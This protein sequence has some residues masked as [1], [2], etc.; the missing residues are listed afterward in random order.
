MGD[1]VGS[2]ADVALAG[3][4]VAAVL[5][6]SLTGADAADSVPAVSGGRDSS[7]L[8]SSSR[9]LRRSLEARLNSPMLLPN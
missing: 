2:S 9:V 6:G 3:G 4:V 1:V 8:I 5:A 7:T